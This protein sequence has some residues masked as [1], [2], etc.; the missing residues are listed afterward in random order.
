MAALLVAST[1]VVVYSRRML[2]RIRNIS[3]ALYKEILHGQSISWIE[4]GYSL[5][6]DISIQFRLYS[7]LYRHDEIEGIENRDRKR[8]SLCANIAVAAFVASMALSF[9]FA[10]NVIFSGR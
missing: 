5:P 4:R 9:L 1:G 7:C 3:P 2:L 6:S 10:W 8:F